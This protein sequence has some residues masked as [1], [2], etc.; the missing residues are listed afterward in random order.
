MIGFE[1][2]PRR[3]MAAASA[4]ASIQFGQL[5]GDDV[6]V[7]HTE[8]RQG[9]GHPVGAACHVAKREGATALAQPLDQ[10]GPIRVHPRP[11]ASS[12]RRQGRLG[13]LARRLVARGASRRG[14]GGR[15]GRLATACP[16]SA[17]T[18]R[19]ATV[20]PYSRQCTPHRVDAASRA[21]ATPVDDRCVSPVR[22]AVRSPAD[23]CRRYAGSRFRAH[24]RICPGGSRRRDVV[25]PLGPVRE[26]RVVRGS[27]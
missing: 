20:H 13:P 23:R 3:S 4:A 16:G 6:A 7:P 1:T 19:A 24:E 14:A 18:I 22:R 8:P 21:A 26:I 10:V 25:I 15:I 12:R 2:A 5:P 17:S 11:R 9:D 27:A